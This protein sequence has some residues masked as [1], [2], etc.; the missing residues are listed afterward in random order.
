MA[1]AYNPE[2]PILQ[3]FKNENGERL[4]GLPTYVDS[5]AEDRYVLWSAIQDQFVNMHCKTRSS[6]RMIFM[7]N[8]DYQVYVFTT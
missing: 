1:M 2:R 5:E 7:T 4:D 6:K 8:K 3:K